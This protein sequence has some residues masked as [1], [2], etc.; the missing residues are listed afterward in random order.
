MLV[1]LVDLEIDNVGIITSLNNSNIDI[2]RLIDMGVT[3]GSKIRLVNKTANKGPI[4]IK[5]RD[6]YIALRY[7][8]ASPILVDCEK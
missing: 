3:I 1:R 6:Y 8:L 4:E 5:V 2:H 7:N